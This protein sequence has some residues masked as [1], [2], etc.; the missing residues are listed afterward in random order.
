MHSVLACTPQTLSLEF[1]LQETRLEE[2]RN[3]TE[4]PAKIQFSFF[5][6]SAV[7][8][9]CVRNCAY[10]YMVSTNLDVFGWATVV[11]SER[12]AQH[13]SQSRHNRAVLSRNT[14]RMLRV[15]TRV[16]WVATLVIRHHDVNG[17]IELPDSWVGHVWRCS[18]RVDANRDGLNVELSQDWQHRACHACDSVQLHTQHFK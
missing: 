9:A 2:F 16:V 14:T 11:G 8:C 5:I 12:K 10:M 18:H 6:Y 1:R 17:V 7:V 3:T 15:R 13:V 4:F